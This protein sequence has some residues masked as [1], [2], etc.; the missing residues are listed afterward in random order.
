MADSSPRIAIAVAV[1]ALVGTL[2]AFAKACATSRIIS[3]RAERTATTGGAGPKD[4]PD[5]T[6]AICG[7]G[8]EHRGGLAR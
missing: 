7:G 8:S 3:A 2:G 6:A 4:D 1:I 5:R